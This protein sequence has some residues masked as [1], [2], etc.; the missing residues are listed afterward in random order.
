MAKA[1]SLV[2]VDAGGKIGVIDPEEDRKMVKQGKKRT[3][4]RLPKVPSGFQRM[5]R[6]RWK[7]HQGGQW[8]RHREPQRHQEGREKRSKPKKQLSGWQWRHR[9]RQRNMLN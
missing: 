4:M 9:E 2:D 3:R 6:W 1:R 5:Q 8:E 7:A